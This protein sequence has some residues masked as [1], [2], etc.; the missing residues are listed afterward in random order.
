MLYR[1]MWFYWNKDQLMTRRGPAKEN[2]PQ[3]PQ[4]EQESSEWTSFEMPLR[5]ESPIPVAFDFTRFLTSSITFMTHLSQVS[6][7]FDDKCLVKLSKSAKPPKVL[8]LPGHLEAQTKS[9]TTRIV[10]FQ[11]T[12][13]YTNFSED[14]LLTGLQPS[15]SKLRL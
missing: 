3:E 13:E 4:V 6:V 8:E 11:S 15:T 2:D 5:E 7:F 9:R 1:W 10:A 12:R 14:L